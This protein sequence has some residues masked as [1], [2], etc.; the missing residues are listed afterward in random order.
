MNH[1]AV[2]LTVGVILGL[3]ASVV[4]IAFFQAMGWISAP[5]QRSYVLTQTIARCVGPAFIAALL[6]LAALQGFLVRSALG[7]AAGMIL[8]LPIAAGVEIYQDPTS[9]NL[10]PFEIVLY[11]GPTFLL[12]FGA[13]LLGR[14]LRDRISGSLKPPIPPVLP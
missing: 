12:A 14:K 5:T 6:L 11:W 8:P 3:T 1:K 13:A 4:L 9:H 10:I 2:R 7:V